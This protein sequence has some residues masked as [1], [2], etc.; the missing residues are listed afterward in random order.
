MHNDTKI[1]MSL[2]ELRIYR[3]KHNNIKVLIYFVDFL[4]KYTGP[5]QT[6]HVNEFIGVFEGIGPIYVHNDNK[7]LISI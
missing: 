7:L 2:Y 6:L 1:L 4:Q 3:N 5:C